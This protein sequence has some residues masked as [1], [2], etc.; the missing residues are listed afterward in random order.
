MIGLLAAVGSH[1]DCCSGLSR[2][3]HT[4]PIDP[5]QWSR[6]HP[7]VYV[8]PQPQPHPKPFSPARWRMRPR[9]ASGPCPWASTRPPGSTHRNSPHCRYNSCCTRCPQPLLPCQHPPPV[10]R[11]GCLPR[12]QH[13][14]QVVAAVLTLERLNEELAKRGM[15][16]AAS[17]DGPHFVQGQRDQAVYYADGA[18]TGI[19]V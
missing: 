17:M 8:C 16:T 3:L 9:R 5:P 6:I 10:G 4:Q 11:F 18:G 19:R 2:G 1:G 14:Q 15:Q 12:P 13:P 7:K